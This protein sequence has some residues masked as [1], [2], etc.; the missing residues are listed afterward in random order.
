MNVLL[1]LWRQRQPKTGR[2]YVLS[3]LGYALMLGLPVLAA[4]QLGHLIDALTQTANAPQILILLLAFIGAEMLANFSRL[5]WIRELSSFDRPLADRLRLIFL[6][7]V[8]WQPEPDRLEN[9]SVFN[10][11]QQDTT[12]LTHLLLETY[13]VVI[14]VAVAAS[15]LTLMVRV[16]VPYTL[17]CLIPAAL[18][19]PLLSRIRRSL[20]DVTHQSRQTADTLSS[21]LQSAVQL[22]PQLAFTPAQAALLERY[23]QALTSHSN[24]TVKTALLQSAVE[25]LAYRAGTV[26]RA[27]LLLLTAP[28]IL[29]GEFTIGQYLIFSAYL[30]WLMNFPNILTA[31]QAS[32]QQAQ[33]AAVRLS[34]TLGL[35]EKNALQSVVALNNA[36]SYAQNTAASSPTLTLHNVTVANGPFKNFSAAVPAQG[37]TVITGPSGS[38]KTTLLKILAGEAGFTGELQ[39]ALHTALLHQQPTFLVGTVRDNLTLTL[40]LPEA[41]IQAAWDVSGLQ[42]DGLTLDSTQTAQQLSG[43]Q[44]QRLALAR[45]LLHGPLTLLLDSPTSA[46]DARTEHHVV[47]ALIRSGRNIVA[48]TNRLMLLEQADAVVY[49]EA[50]QVLA[51]GTH[52]GMMQSHARYRRHVQ[53]ETEV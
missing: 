24:H 43:G 37:F 45:T 13:R 34:A 9:T 39:P 44:Q 40:D 22:A 35:A 32:W 41:D 49:L 19:P 30:E 28:A 11:H 53:Q 50:G 8:I 3:A 7:R 27:G 17:A 38:G 42:D 1:A 10:A 33:Q 25:E 2:R 51:T 18:V 47:Q 16:S 52:A 20:V 26:L 46:L 4:Q 14:S 36:A 21:Q 15:A 29:R 48:A 23:S 31:A 6:H 12:R 5:L